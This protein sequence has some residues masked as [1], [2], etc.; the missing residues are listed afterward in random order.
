ML[1][2][3]VLVA[4]IAVFP[5]LLLAF[6]AGPP[7]GVTGAFGESDCTDC[8]L[9][10]A[11]NVAGGSL[12]ISGVPTNYTP[13]GPPIP[14]TVT[15]SKS[16]QRRWG[17]ELAVRA[18]A[19][20]AQAG[21]LGV[22]STTRI[23]TS[24]NIQYISHNTSGTQ[25]NASQGTWTFNWTPPSSNAGE[26]VF[27]AASNAANGDGTNSGDFIYTRQVSSFAQAQVTSPL[28]TKPVLTLVPHF[29]SGGNFV[30][31]VQIN[32]LSASPN[33][34]VIN[35]VNQNGQLATAGQEQV[36]A[37]NA[38]LQTSTG[39]AN[40][41]APLSVQW[42]AIGSDG[43]I[44]ASVLFDCCAAGTTVSSAVGVLPQTPA[45]SFKAPLLFQQGDA[46]TPLLTEGLALANRS[47]QTNNLT[48]TLFNS[49]GTQAASDTLTLAPFNQTAFDPFFTTPSPTPN[50]R[51]FL[52]TQ[53]TYF[54]TLTITGTQLFAP[55]Y[56][57]NLGGRLFSLP[58]TGQ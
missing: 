41:T 40:R 55:V 30:T 10:N 17:F 14:I 2:L 6:S 28:P 52:A 51:A 4:L 45:T 21:I 44:S 13:G 9:G 57:G 36:L 35:T 25:I 37:A 16:G 23:Q 19:T 12:T 3:R 31:R 38:G 5:A 34:V 32:N 54:G 29:V 27:A 42:L 22:S 49:D 47:D 26:I 20:G 18:R 48:L 1:K 43:A 8:H 7:P 53:T 33:G 50:I 58:L 39:E 56:V 15:I 11:L 24:T 46:T